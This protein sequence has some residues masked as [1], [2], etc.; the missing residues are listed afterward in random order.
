[1]ARKNKLYYGD[2]LV[3]LRQH[4]ADESVDLVYLDPPFNSNADYNILFKEKDGSDAASQ[5]R[6][7]EDTWH[8]DEAS[9]AAFEDAV[10]N[11][12]QRVA[13]ALKALRGLVGTNDMLAYLSMMAPRLFELRKKLKSHGSI[14]LHCDPKASHYLKVLMDAV[15]GKDKFRSEIIWRRTGAHSKSKRWAPVHD[16]IL[17]YTKTDQYTWNVPKKPFMKG[18]IEQNFV[19]DERGWRTDYYGNVLTGSGRRGGESG[20]PW[21]GVDPTAK[22]RHWAIPGALL[23]DL[24]EDLSNL[25]QHQK[26]DR[27]LELGWIKFKEGEEWPVYERYLT[28]RDGQVIPDIW[29]YQPYAEGT[30]FK[31]D[32][33]IDADVRWLGSKDQERLHYPTQKPEGLLERIINASSNK[34]DVVLDPFCGCGTTVV[35]A[36]RLKRQWVGIDITY[37]AISLIKVRLKK[38]IPSKVKYQIEGE[39]ASVEDARA[40]ANQDRYQF[41]WWALNLVNAM[42]HEKKKG[43]DQGIDGRLYFFAQGKKR[44]VSTII[45]SVKSGNVSVRD[46]RELTSVVNREHAAIGVLITLLKPTKPMKKEAASAGFFVTLS[47]VE[48]FPKIQILSIDQLLRGKKIRY[49]GQSANITFGAVGPIRRKGKHRQRSLLEA[50]GPAA[51]EEE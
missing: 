40:L 2:N 16:V 32:A 12:D 13:E 15:F 43:A 11:C 20:M 50:N 24:G 36:E 37:M 48:K 33:G 19:Q 3:F 17:F 14:Y 1:M 6:A 38:A 46:V 49:P 44:D 10:L 41:Q 51:T 21:H 39:P 8:W 26:L 7:F 5:I 29:A 28:D 27:F 31:S 18:H 45:I 22:G 47:Y 9:A 30:V 4:I 35:A 23:S 25:T 42:P 34:G